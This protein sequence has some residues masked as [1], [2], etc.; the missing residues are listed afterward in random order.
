[1]ANDYGLFNRSQVVDAAIGGVT[2]I[3]RMKARSFQV[4]SVQAMI[5]GTT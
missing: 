3:R 5:T 4:A 2:R 1:L